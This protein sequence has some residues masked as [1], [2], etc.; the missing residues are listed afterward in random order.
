MN[1]FDVRQDSKQTASKLVTRLCGVVCTDCGW[2][3][4]RVGKFKLNLTQ[5]FHPYP[6]TL[7]IKGKP[8]LSCSQCGR[9]VVFTHVTGWVRVKDL[10]I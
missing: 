8:S 6:A 1:I 2:R 7:A 3:G 4:Y 10:V 9:S 5:Q